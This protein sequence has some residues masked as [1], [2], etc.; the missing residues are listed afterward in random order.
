MSQNP[1]TL[2]PITTEHSIHSIIEHK[3]VQPHFQGIVDF[4]N[5]KLMGFESL[6]R[7][8]P[9]VPRIAPDQLFALAQQESCMKQLDQMC[10][11]QTLA[12]VQALELQGLI[13]I[14]MLP[15]TLDSFCQHLQEKRIRLDGITLEISEKYPF[16]DF[17][18]LK[19]HV[20]ILRKHGALI[21]I[22]DLGAGYSGLIAW[23]EIRP[24]FVKIDR[25]FVHHIHIDGVKRE[26]VRSI[27]EVARGL[28]CQVI[29]E[30]IETSGELEVLQSIGIKL[31][32]GYFLHRPEAKP[33]RVTI[34]TAF[35][36]SS[37]V[38]PKQVNTR[39]VDTAECLLEKVPPLL[40]KFKAELVNDIFK[41]D[42]SISSIPVVNGTKPVGII[43]RAQILELFSGRYSHQLHGHKPIENFMNTQPIVVD[44]QDNLQ[45]ISKLIT[46][47][48]D[49]DL[50]NSFI[51]THNREY[52]GAGKVA[53]LLKHIT[54]SQ[55]RYARYSNPLTLLPGNV[56]IFEWIDDLL[57]QQQD[58]WIAY[59][60]IN[61]F[62]PFNDYYGYS[63][64]DEVISCLSEIIVNN[65][66]ANIDL[67]G[68]V[69]GDDF[70]VI[71]RSED[72]EQR[73]YNMLHH[74]E[75]TIK[76]F[77]SK[78]ELT[79]NGIWSED[80]QGNPTFY[81]LITL[82]IGA[83]NP[84]IRCC[85]SHH[86]VASLASDAKHKAKAEGGNHLFVCRRRS[87]KGSRL[88]PSDQLKNENKRA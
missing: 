4:A 10:V 40:P 70:V 17:E 52:V 62:K 20:A 22:D 86:D 37:K 15:C 19:S 2:A 75:E 13:F 81:N 41:R 33:Y 27:I 49:T 58:F 42:P 87:T 59:F 65:A 21:A 84:D 6:V 73:C 85:Q 28:N 5:E 16:N 8:A 24:D 12:Q 66:S 71:F 32:Q 38:S 67:V 31:G 39:L 56:P 35:L 45:D 60:D 74:F 29:A 78:K 44:L 1:A 55:I 3:K 47:K 48:T 25:H 53:K 77:Y 69:G 88:I 36:R 54:D 30:G 11:E 61:H 72:W 80:R 68:H 18:K 46:Q 76:Q 57:K 51:I 43:S 50:N 7:T 14:N 9:S 26:F 79:E 83:A 34:P 63:R 23:A 82:A 64:G